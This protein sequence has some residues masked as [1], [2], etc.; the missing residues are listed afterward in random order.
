MP[1]E[2]PAPTTSVLELLPLPKVSDLSEARRRGATCV[3]CDTPLT[4]ETARDLGERPAPDGGQL[5]PRGCSPCVRRTAVRVHNVHPRTCPRCAD[6][7]GP[8][9]TRRALH[10]LAMEGR[11]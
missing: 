11:R 6:N 8:C 2:T 7:K 9:Y 1:G 3:W 5:F 4:A 10:S